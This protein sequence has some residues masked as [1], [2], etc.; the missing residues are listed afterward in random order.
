MTDAQNPSLM[1]AVSGKAGPLARSYVAARL[2]AIAVAIAGAVPTAHTLYQS[3][4]NGIPYSE[5]SHRLAQYDLWVKN[6]ECEIDYRVLDTGQGTRVDVGACPKSGDIAIKVSTAKGGS[7]Y[8]WVP[9]AKIKKT[10]AS[11]SVWELIATTA[12][13]QS[14][15]L[16]PT[17]P[18]HPAQARGMQ[19]KCQAMQPGNRIIRI[20]QEGTQCFRES[21][22][23]LQGKTE[24]RDPVACNTQ[25][26]PSR[27]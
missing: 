25:C 4:A 10:Q 17:A 11:A 2:G 6:F 20:V 15:A 22:L 14:T 12:H 9:Y 19:V 5:V 13:A 1:S 21:I 26:P 8:E 7:A 27:R 16:P 23:A 18:I 3:Y 24:K